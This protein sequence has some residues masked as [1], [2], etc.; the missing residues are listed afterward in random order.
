M[1]VQFV[2]APDADTMLAHLEVTST[3]PLSRVVD[4]LF[5]MSVEAGADVRLA[6]EGE[7]TRSGL[8]MRLADEQD[9]IRIAEALNRAQDHGN[10]EEVMT[11]LW[12]IVAAL[13]PNRDDRWEAA[14]GR[15]V[16]M[17]EVGAEDGIDLDSARWHVEEPQLGDVVAVPVHNSHHIH[18]LAWRWLNEA[19][20]GLAET[21]STLH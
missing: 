18:T 11:R 2:A 19:Y 15:I 7:I 4:L 1:P 5:G 21:H 17:K 10:A 8:W 9:R 12:A 13:R 3:V 16:E 6:G 20:P 14:T